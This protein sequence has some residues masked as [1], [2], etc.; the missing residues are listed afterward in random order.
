M[1]NDRTLGA[2]PSREPRVPRTPFEAIEKIVEYL[3]HL[4]DDAG[5]NVTRV[6]DWLNARQRREHWRDAYFERQRRDLMRRLSE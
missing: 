4:H 2:E 3:E 5:G 6:R 1:A